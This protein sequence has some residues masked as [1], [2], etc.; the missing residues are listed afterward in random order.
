MKYRCTT[1][2]AIPLLHHNSLLQG[3]D[4]AQRALEG[5]GEGGTISVGVGFNPKGGSEDLSSEDRTHLLISSP[6]SV[7][8]YLLLL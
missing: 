8:H 1:I 5:E 7:R 3:D 2:H 6:H 4:I